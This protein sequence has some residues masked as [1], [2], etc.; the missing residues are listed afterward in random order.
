MAAPATT[1]PAVAGTGAGVKPIIGVPFY[2]MYG[3]IGELSTAPF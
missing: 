2:S 3:H 1:H